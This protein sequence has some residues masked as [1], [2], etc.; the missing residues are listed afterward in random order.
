MA[1]LND[2]STNVSIHDDTTE[3]NARVE[4]DN[5]GKGRLLVQSVNDEDQ[6]DSFGRLRVSN[7]QTLFDSTLQYGKNDRFWYE[8]V[9]G[10]GASS[11]HL[12]DESSVRLRVGTVS[13]EKVYRRTN[14][15]FRYQPGK[16]QNITM[17]GTLGSGKANVRRRI[18]YFDDENGVFFELDGTTLY[19][20][21]RSNATGSVVDTRVAQS[22]WNRDP[23][24]G[25][26]A[27]GFT[28]D[29]SKANIFAFDL[30][31]LGVGR[32]RYSVNIDGQSI[33]VH[34]ID[35]ANENTTVYM[36]TAN[37]PLTYEIENTGTAASQSDLLQICSSI[38]S[39]GGS[40][41]YDLA[42]RIFSQFNLTEK[43]IN[44][45]GWYPIIAVRLKST[46]NSI[47]NRGV[48]FPV[49]VEMLSSTTTA[50]AFTL[51]PTSLTGASWTSVDTDS[52]CEYDVSATA[53]TGG[54]V[55]SYRFVPSG[56]N[57]QTTAGELPLFRGPLSLDAPGTTSDV[58]LIAARSLSGTGQARA[59]VTWSELY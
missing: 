46:F 37:L 44:A 35:N 7:L 9:S 25:T 38:Q 53:Y 58:L 21:L 51:N 50:L 57:S 41:E 29:T 14:R 45:S 47:T 54:T 3:A 48:I 24:D 8:S 42:G 1:D 26:G 27:S 23:L 59:S 52:I 17:T 18:G 43:S 36:T 5:Q 6:S 40:A 15:Y 20:V 32:V 2:L 11:T 19:I 22:S 56:G 55:L 12:P 10:A 28:L 31:W 4:L 39:E 13:G 16:S 30:Q 49:L 33:F 34:E